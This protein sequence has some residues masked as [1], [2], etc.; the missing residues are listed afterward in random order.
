[1]RVVAAMVLD[2]V[3]LHVAWLESAASGR[4]VC[5]LLS[6]DGRVDSEVDRVGPAA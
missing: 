3:W 5:F 1:M 6:R 4:E 2:L